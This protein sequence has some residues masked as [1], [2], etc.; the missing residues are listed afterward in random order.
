MQHDQEESIGQLSV[1]TRARRVLGQILLVL[2]VIA[3]LL[4]QLV[5]AWTPL[6]RVL[7][8]CYDLGRVPVEAYWYGASVLVVAAAVSI[9]SWMR[10]AV[11]SSGVLAGTLLA[12]GILTALLCVFVAFVSAGFWTMWHEDFSA[13]EW[14]G[15]FVVYIAAYATPALALILAARLMFVRRKDEPLSLVVPTAAFLAFTLASVALQVIRNWVV[16]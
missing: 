2:L 7:A 5:A 9:T 10:R 6:S 16:C 12:V 1:L 4:F 14:W 11:D 13:A 15:Q 8:E 3:A